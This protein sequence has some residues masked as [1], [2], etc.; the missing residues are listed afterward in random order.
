MSKII[1]LKKLT[2]KVGKSKGKSLATKSTIAVKR[3]VIGK[4]RPREVFD[5]LPSKKGKS[6]SVAP[7]GNHVTIGD[8]KEG[9]VEFY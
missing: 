7:Q 8:K 2:Q 3:V 1:S 9:D 5:T 6:S 4:K